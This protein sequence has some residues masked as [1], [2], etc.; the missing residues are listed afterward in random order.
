MW[1]CV[2]VVVLCLD[3]VILFFFSSRRRHT[4]CALVTGVQTCAL[5][6]SPSAFAPAGA[7]PRSRRSATTFSTGRFFGFPLKRHRTAPHPTALFYGCRTPQGWLCSPLRSAEHTAELP[8]LM[9]A[10]YAGAGLQTYRSEIP[11]TNT[12]RPRRT[13]IH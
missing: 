7:R 8:S 1:L 12:Q 11:Y 4:S 10:P 3:L 5:P 13:P 9:R 2:V 6:I